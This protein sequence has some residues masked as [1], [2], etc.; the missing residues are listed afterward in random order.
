VSMADG[1]L[2]SACY[3]FGAKIIGVV[4]NGVVKK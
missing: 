4:N 3:Q 1:I 2:N